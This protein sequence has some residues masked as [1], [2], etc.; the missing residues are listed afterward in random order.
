MKKI[1]ISDEPY[2]L[3]PFKYPWAY[4]KYLNMR[5]N[6][7]EP[8]QIAMGA[9]KYCFD[10]Q[11]TSSEKEMFLDVFAMLT[12]SDMVIQEN[13][14]CRIYDIIKPPECRLF[15]G[16]QLSDESLH[17]R[18][19]QHIIDILSLGDDNIYKRYLT[20]PA[21]GQKFEV[22]RKYADFLKQDDPMKITI[23]L[24]FFYLGWEGIWFYH[25]FTPIFSLK[26]RGLMMGTSEQL[27]YIARDE[28]T[29][30]DF[31]LSL[32]RT[33]IEEN[34][35]YNDPY[36]IEY[37][38]RAFNDILKGEIIYATA[39]IPQLVGYSSEDH[40]AY[41]RFLINFRLEQLNLPVIPFS[42]E[43]C[44]NTCPWLTEIY[45]AKKEKNFFETHVTEY[46]S[47]AALEFEEEKQENFV[48]DL[49]NWK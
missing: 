19:Y 1:L 5:Q 8:T 41:T 28:S 30:F 27:E 14:C 37:V 24:I 43:N 49:V 12:T 20:K 22:A 15:I 18:S 44:W 48:G 6:F 34:N 21:I 45:Q 26:R 32:C 40:L 47:G 13:L 46:R 38:H 36:F 10:T 23:A 9:D 29:H 2:N 16:Q 33:L 25:G 11:L 4:E 39:C 3:S 7:W 31:G 42:P 35:L 17:S